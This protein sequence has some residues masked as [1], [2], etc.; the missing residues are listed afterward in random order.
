MNEHCPS[1][2]CCCMLHTLG[3]PVQVIMATN[4]A[5]TLDPALLRPGRLDRKIEFPLPDRRQKRLVFQ[6][7]SCRTSFWNVHWLPILCAMELSSVRPRPV[8]HAIC[9]LR[10]VPHVMCQLTSHGVGTLGNVVRCQTIGKH[11]THSSADRCG[12]CSY[13]SP[14]NSVTCSEIY[15]ILVC[16][17]APQA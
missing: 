9:L 7:R 6:A 2:W 11:R 10:S 17:H 15:C 12:R 1:R 13:S 3:W 14:P 8:P 5:D 16:R 4:R